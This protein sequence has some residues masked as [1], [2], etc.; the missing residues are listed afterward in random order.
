MEM[1]SQSSQIVD[2]GQLIIREEQCTTP[3]HLPVLHLICSG[4]FDGFQEGPDGK[5]SAYFE[6]ILPQKSAR[7]IVNIRQVTVYSDLA[8]A[9]VMKL[10]GRLRQ[11]HGD[12]LVAEPSGAVRNIMKCLQM[13]FAQTVEDAMA[14][15]DEACSAFP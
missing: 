2:F 10:A 13:P 11:Q 14:Q 12:V 9:L 15:L 8:P 7:I 1:L 6:H 5:V 4:Y 3:H